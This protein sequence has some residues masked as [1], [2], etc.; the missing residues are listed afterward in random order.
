VQTTIPL[1]REFHKET[2]SLVRVIRN[3]PKKWLD[4]G[5]GTGTMV[6]DAIKL[7]AETEFFLADPAKAMLDIATEKLAEYEN[8]NIKFLE[9]VSTQDL[10]F[11]DNTFDVITAIQAHHYLDF[12][13]R[14]MATCNCFRVLKNGG[15]YITFEN[16]K[17]LT[18]K[19][20]EVGLQRWKNFQVG[21]G[22]PED[23]ADRHMDRFGKEYFPI[24]VIDHVKLLKGSGF[25]I[26]ELFWM[27]YM[28]AGFY[29]VKE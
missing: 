27:S 21:E 17:P 16:I 15:V 26:V 12:E 29:A 22:K 28:Q 1:Y 4:T 18:A 24:T 23:E 19:G 8:K 3:N 11:P 14:K 20:I 2:L 9:P 5:C 13:T 10:D 25:S 6:L 7:F